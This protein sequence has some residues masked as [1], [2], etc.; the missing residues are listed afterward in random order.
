MGISFVLQYHKQV[1][2]L[3]ILVLPKVEKKR[4]QQ[5]I[6]KKLTTD[7]VTF[8]KPLRRSL[9]GYRSLRVGD[10]RVIFSIKNNVVQI[11][12]I[13]HRSAVYEDYMKRFD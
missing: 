3:D 13:G 10:Y 12:A 2:K 1:V 6:L 7:P 5:A 4:I 11:F 9:A 8:G